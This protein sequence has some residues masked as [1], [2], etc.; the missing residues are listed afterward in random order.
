MG[1]ELVLN[2]LSFVPP[3]PDK[4]AAR[5]RVEGFHR[6]A[7]AAMKMGVNHCVRCPEGFQRKFL[8]VGYSMGDWLGDKDVDRD[9]RMA[10]KSWFTKAPYWQGDF[11][12]EQK[13]HSRMFEFAEGENAI[14]MGVAALLNGLGVS[15]LSNEAWD[16]SSVEIRVL[17][18]LFNGE[19]A[20][21]HDENIFVRHVSRS[22]H[23]EVHKQ[24]IKERLAINPKD[25]KELWDMRK[26]WFSKLDF[27]EKT[28]AQ[29]I[30]L[31]REFLSS[32][33]E[34]LVELQKYCQDWVEGNFDATNFPSKR[35]AVEGETTLKKFGAE[36]TFK[37]PDDVMRTFSW[38]VKIGAKIR[39]Y[40]E[41]LPNAKRIIIGYIGPHLRIVTRS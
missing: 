31:Q 13:V 27:C 7:T 1:I 21:T 20:L 38:H 30:N 3:A 28:E 22:K 36:R 15:F 12:L 9:L 39:I 35:I 26:D 8:A 25:G 16:R 40:F 14:G 29:L 37:C 41:P 19:E 10:L 11:D 4:A 5:L 32:V 24:W 23:L 18:E 33:T 17:T 6:A 34:H 2:E